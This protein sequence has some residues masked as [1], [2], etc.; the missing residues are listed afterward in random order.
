MFGKMTSYMREAAGEMKRVSW[1]TLAELSES[2][3]VVI[4]TVAVVTVF[5]FFVDQILSFIQ[6]KLILMS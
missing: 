1:P 6:K 2:T 4:A 5:V 3:R